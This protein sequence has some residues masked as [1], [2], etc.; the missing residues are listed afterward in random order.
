MEYSALCFPCK[1]L[2]GNKVH[3]LAGNH[4]GVSADR[5]RLCNSAAGWHLVSD[6]TSRMY[7]CLW[8]IV[9]QEVG[10]CSEVVVVAAVVAAAVVAV[11][12]L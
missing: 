11:T 12:V 3:N 7:Q 4:S 8:V 9:K 5:R 2:T 6:R 10:P 1:D